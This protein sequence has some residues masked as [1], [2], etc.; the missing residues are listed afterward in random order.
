[1]TNQRLIVPLYPLSPF[2]SCSGFEESDGAFYFACAAMGVS[3]TAL[4]TLMYAY[5]R[6]KRIL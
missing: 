3:S 5:C 6:S 1:M 2:V 4:W